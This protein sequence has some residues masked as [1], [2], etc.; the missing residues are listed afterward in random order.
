[1]DESLLELEKEL[2]RL[3]PRD[4]SA[5]LL[6]RIEAGLN[7]PDSQPEFSRSTASSKLVLWPWLNW[8]VA[9][10][11]AAVVV[12]ATVVISSRLRFT[13]SGTPA[14][15]APQAMAAADTSA[16][17]EVSAVVPALTV[18]DRYQPVGAATVLYDL[19]E[20]AVVTQPNS[21]P[22]RRLRY[23]YVD[24]YTWKNPATNASLK[25]SVPR[26]EVR[27]LPASLH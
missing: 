27:V 3:R 2:K 16:A 24:T 18:T 22:A 14:E 20:D 17:S 25:W 1:M 12:F 10:A 6:K 15:T 4:L 26:D 8:W 7:A 13:P 23:R 21:T 11:A 9:A 5:T 19:K